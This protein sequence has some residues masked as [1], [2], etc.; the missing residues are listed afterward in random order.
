MLRYNGDGTENNTAFVGK[1]IIGVCIFETRCDERRNDLIVYDMEKDEVTRIAY[2]D[3]KSCV[4]CGPFL[5]TRYCD[6]EYDISDAL[7]LKI[8]T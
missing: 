5:R 8:M 2:D 1:D 6:L 7:M 3:Y 4:G